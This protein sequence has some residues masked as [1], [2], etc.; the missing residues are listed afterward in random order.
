M[1]DL[2]DWSLNYQS[3]RKQLLQLDMRK[4]IQACKYKKVKYYS[5][6]KIILIN[7]IIH[8]IKQ[9]SVTWSLNWKHI[10]SAIN[11]ALYGKIASIVS[12]IVSSNTFNHPISNK[13]IEMILRKLRIK[14]K[15][16]QN[17]LNYITIVMKNARQ[18]RANAFGKKIRKR[19]NQKIGY[20]N[21]IDI[22]FAGL[23][24]D[25]LYDIYNVHRCFIFANY[26][27]TQYETNTF[28]ENIEHNNFLNPNKKNKRFITKIKKLMQQNKEYFIPT[29]DLFPQYAIED[30][31]YD[32]WKYFFA[33]SH[34]IH[35]IDQIIDDVQ[36]TLKICVIPN[37]IVSIYD[38]EITFE[39]NMND[40]NAF[41]TTKQCNYFVSFTM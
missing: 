16:T 23:N 9:Y 34:F 2:V 18:F 20:G 32:I 27:F 39:Y 37:R 29:I 15:I 4:L 6:K 17:E 1:A 26:Q 22:A 3:L 36:L 14:Y 21:D 10:V 33:A 19:N 28:I 40:L 12:V 13:S 41:F 8:K 30:D 25:I 24:I 31:M 35:E 7:G 5:N 38:K 11:Q